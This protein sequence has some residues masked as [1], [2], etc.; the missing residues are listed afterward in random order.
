MT[1]EELQQLP[2][3][4]EIVGF[5]LV[6]KTARDTFVD[7]DEKAWQEVLFMDRTGEM[8]GQILLPD[9]S[10]SDDGSKYDQRKKVPPKVWRS[11][12]RV[13]IIEGEIQDSDIRR[14]MGKKLVVTECRDMNVQ[15][16]YDQYDD[17]SEAEGKSA[18]E[19]RHR[20]IRGKCMTLFIQSYIEGMAV[21]SGSLA[22]PDSKTEDILEA[23]VNIA[24]KEG[25]NDA[26]RALL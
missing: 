24:T 21:W 13:F 1:L 8:S 7:G 6:I 10:P 14:K 15:L 17:L 26:T 9:Y 12:E 25:M 2:H 23:W 19:A 5:S 18:R 22:Q 4:T 11:K 20:E 16:T 3:G